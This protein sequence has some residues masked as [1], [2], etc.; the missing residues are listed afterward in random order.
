MQTQI[1][2]IKERARK[3]AGFYFTAIMALALFGLGVV[4]GQAM[5]SKRLVTQAAENSTWSTYLINA[6]RNQN[7]SKEIDFQQFWTVWDKVKSKYAKQPVKDEDLFYG[8][9]QGMVAGLGD[10]YTVY[11][12][13]KQA[14]EFNKSLDGEFSGIGAEI[15]IK[16]NQL[17]IVA[18]LPGTPAEKAGLLPGDKI[19][20][21]DK[22]VSINMDSN[23][24][25]EKIR[26]QAGTPVT[27]N[28]MRTGFA[29][30]KD[31]VIT[32]AK[33]NVPSVM[34]SVKNKNIGYIRIMQFNQSTVPEFDKAIKELQTKK[35]TKLIVDLRNNPGGY[36]DSA[37]WVASEWLPE[38]KVVSE[39]FSNGDSQDHFSSGE[40]RLQNIKTVVLVNGGSA[41]A[42]EIL[43]GALQ[44]TK[45]ATIVGE[46]TFGKGSVQDYE[47]LGDG[48]ALKVTIAEWYTPND[49]NINEQ[50]IKPDVEVK[51]EWSKEKVGEDAMLQKAY[52][53]FVSKPIVNKTPVSVKK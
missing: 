15:G 24:A 6:D 28:I 14:E 29:K 44:D 20:A 3:Y 26:G 34:F 49:K 19:Y 46:K 43:A 32:R 4:A 31:F 9:M 17:V 5:D 48:S 42:S 25:V 11:M 39:K 33:I 51:Q 35:L 2:P 40:H 1:N 22:V 8:A 30:P 37:V 12:P 18:P 16:N 23:T 7:N 53:L 38:G 47:M 52:S 41:S 13:P 45:K 50:G 10:P 21:I 36:L 27:L